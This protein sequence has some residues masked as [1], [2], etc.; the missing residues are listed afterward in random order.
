MEAYY[1]NIIYKKNAFDD[2]KT[3]IKLN[4]SR[5]NI[6]LVSTKSIQPEDVTSILN[7]LF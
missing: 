6:L 7:S 3:Y 5:K 4:Y 1:K 2:L